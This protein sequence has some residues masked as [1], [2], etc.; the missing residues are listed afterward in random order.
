LPSSR[1]KPG[2]AARA[3]DEEAIRLG[4]GN[5]GERRAIVG[6]DGQGRDGE[7]LLAGE[8]EDDPAGRQHPETG[9]RA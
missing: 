8:T 6:G 9:R 3:L 1:A 2:W 7:I 5:L 4:V